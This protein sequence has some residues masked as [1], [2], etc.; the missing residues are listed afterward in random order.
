MDEIVASRDESELKT[1]SDILNDAI[2]EWLAKFLEEHSERFP[3]MKDRF[4]LEHIKHL[5][6]SRQRDLEL[7]INSTD[8]AVREDNSGVLRPILY[9][10]VRL[11]NELKNDPYGSPKQIKDLQVQIERVQREM[12]VKP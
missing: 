10:A 4:E 1:R 8:Q 12:G 9:N 5:Y 2:H 11:M 6:D 7:I 3:T